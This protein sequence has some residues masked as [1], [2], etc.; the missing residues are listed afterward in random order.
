MQINV[1][2][3]GG[4]Y[5]GSVKIDAYVLEQAG[6]PLVLRSLALREPGPGE[7][8]VEVLGCGLCHTDL[9]FAD[10]SVRPNKGLPIILGH[11]VTGRVVAAGA[12]A[13]EAVGQTVLV[14]S[15]MPC[16]S[17]AYCRAGRGNACPDQK[18]PG[19]D[20][21][22]GFATH[23]LAPA[24][25]LVDLGDIPP[26]DARAYGVVADAVSTAYQAAV[27]ADLGAGDLAMVVGAGGVGGFLIQDARAFGARVLACDVQP[28]R[29]EFVRN[30][31]ADEV[32][33]VTGLSPRDVRSH[34]KGVARDF[35]ISPHRWRVFECSGSTAGQQTAFGTLQRGATL[36]I[37]GF[38]PDKVT[39]RLS[40]LMAFDATVHGS[41]GCPVELYPAV[42]QL[43]RT[44]AVQLE[45]FIDFAPMSQLNDCLAA[46][47]SHD[48]ERRMIL[49]PGPGRSR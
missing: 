16:G 21:D 5:P 29:L 36:V 2:C 34:V 28:D 18:M 49:Q 47:A 19:N 42:L 7:A 25:A 35:G 3:A 26:D 31:G 43:V 45:P 6:E 10:G 23:M 12:G 11:E 20:I 4:L 1:G 8:V 27:R 13:E 30:H 22:G 15:V 38:T 9:G 17:C 14:P 46:L 24:S 40:N 39:L 48:L 33:D 32:L 44:G 41:W 37:V